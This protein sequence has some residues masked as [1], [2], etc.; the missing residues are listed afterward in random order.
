MSE[1]MN[2]YSSYLKSLSVFAPELP[3]EILNPQRIRPQLISPFVLQLPTSVLQSVQSFTTELFAVFN[4]PDYLR[5]LPPGRDWQSWPSTPCVLNCLDFHYRPETGL[6]LI[7]IN[8]NASLYLASHFL[9]P[10][11]GLSSPDADLLLLQ[12][13][14]Q[15]AFALKAGDE[16]LLVDRDPQKEG[17]YFE[18]LL[19][20]RW[21]ESLGYKARILPLNQLLLGQIERVY[22]RSTDFFLETA[23]SAALKGAYLQGLARVSPNPY[24][25]FVMA[26]K[27]RLSLIRE[28]IALEQRSLIPESRLFRSYADKEEIWQQRKKLFF[29]PSQSYGS[30]AVFSGKGIS[31]RAFDNIYSGD[32][33]AQEYCPAGQ[34]E[35][36]FEGANHTMKFDLRFYVFQGRVQSYLARLYQGQA[37]N[38]RTP[39]GGNAPIRWL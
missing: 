33:L 12:E 32:F 4:N 11:Q 15:Q 10:L 30:K 1:Q 8:T 36:Q 2:L 26:D 34:Q 20:K 7:E 9:Y 25:Y 3:E 21:L 31:R 22:N 39:L 23:E 28:L 24:G 19:Y 17:L 35:F 29:K 27:Q 13:S 37:T 5:Q 18:F 14:F 16:V 6:K 38:M